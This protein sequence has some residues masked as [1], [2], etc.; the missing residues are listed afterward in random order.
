MSVGAWCL[1][2][3]RDIQC[4]LCTHHRVEH[5]QTQMVAEER[6][7]TARQRVKSGRRR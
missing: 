3:L 4:W 2:F 1:D 7:V 5:S 6:D